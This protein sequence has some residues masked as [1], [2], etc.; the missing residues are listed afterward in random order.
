MAAHQ[1]S[2]IS[3]KSWSYN[4]FLSTFYKHRLG[5]KATFTV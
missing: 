5:E 3:L 1:V 4:S 2:N